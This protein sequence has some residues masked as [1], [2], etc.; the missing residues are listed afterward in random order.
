MKYPVLLLL[1]LL[2]L[3][4]FVNNGAPNVGVDFVGSLVFKLEALVAHL[5]PLTVLSNINDN[6]YAK[7][8]DYR[9]P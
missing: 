7:R 3:L 4:L 5:S 9:I 2:L 6:P 1:L 8:R